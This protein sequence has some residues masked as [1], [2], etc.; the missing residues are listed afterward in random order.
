MIRAEIHSLESNDHLNW[1]D[2]AAYES[3]DPYDD[4]GWFHITIGA[5]GVEGGNDFQICVATHRAVGRAKRSGSIQGLLVNRFNA[6]SVHNAIHDRINS[7]EAYAWNQFVDECRTF[8][9][10]EYEGKGGP[11]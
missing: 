5:V 4:F 9:K 7:I 3:P 6:Q 11:S 1:S 8:M 10:W 2:F